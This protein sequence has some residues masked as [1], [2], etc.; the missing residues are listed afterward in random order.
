MKPTVLV[1]H[2]ITSQ[3]APIVNDVHLH[4]DGANLVALEIDMK[5][6]YCTVD[7]SSEDEGIPCIHI[8]ANDSS[9]KL[10]ENFG[11]TESTGISFPEY[12]GWDVY[13]TGAGRYS[14]RVVLIRKKR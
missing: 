6:K 4:E 3:G 9:L 8:E 10:N 11:L 5:S 1:K 7:M 13:A 12:K 14:I 2:V